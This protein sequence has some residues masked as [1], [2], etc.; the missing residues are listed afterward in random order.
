M[1]KLNGPS[2]STGPLGGHE[3]REDEYVFPLGDLLRILWQRLWI[4]VSVTIVIVGAALGFT[5]AQAPS[6]QASI[7]ILV[8]QQQGTDDN[9]A[10]EVQGLQ[11]LTAT[12]A[13][14]VD[15]RPVAEA[16]IDEL[17]LRVPP[18]EFLENLDAE[19]VNG[20]QFLEVSYEDTSPQSAQQIVNTVGEVFSIQVSEVGSS[21]IPITARVWEQAAYPEFPVSPK[22]S[23]SA[24]VALIMGSM[25]GIGL[26]LLLEYLDDSWRS[27]EEAE[28]VSGVPTY[29]VIPQFELVEAPKKASK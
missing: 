9:L 21:A 13:E 1:G 17:D 16:V 27:P 28:Q 25:L 22:P 26:A 15:T 10:S 2:R 23:L 5:L 6:Y 20:T 8:G 24:L 3:H 29:G 11:Q 7:K 12:M 19:Q 4:I 18:D 14:A